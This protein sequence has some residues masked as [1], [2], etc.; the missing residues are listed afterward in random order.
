MY[1]DVK[2][3]GKG[4]VKK[5]KHQMKENIKYIFGIKQSKISSGN[6]FSLYYICLQ[7]EVREKPQNK[8]KICTTN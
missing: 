5:K 7:N 4:R 3:C 8:G 2:T 1:E 6:L